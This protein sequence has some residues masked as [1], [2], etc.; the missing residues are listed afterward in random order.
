MTYYVARLKLSLNPFC[1]L[2]SPN[3]P[4]SIFLMNRQVLRSVV[5]RGLI[6]CPFQFLEWTVL[7]GDV[8]GA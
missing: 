1:N 4:K 8:R 5:K 2:L 6:A 3:P 7:S